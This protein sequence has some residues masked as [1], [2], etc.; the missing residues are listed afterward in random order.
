MV[1]E[2]SF[3][4]LLRLDNLKR[5]V[6]E[7]L[8][9]PKKVHRKKDGWINKTLQHFSKFH[10]VLGNL[11]KINLTIPFTLFKVQHDKQ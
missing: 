1:S 10:N 9:S 3:E 2:W 11:F 6:R 4:P 5:K 8:L 7:M